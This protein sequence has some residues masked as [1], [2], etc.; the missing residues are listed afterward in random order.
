MMIIR[1]FVS[2]TP[3]L[4]WIG[5]KSVS[6]YFKGSLKASIVIRDLSQRRPRRPCCNIFSTA[7]AAPHAD[8]NFRDGLRGSEKADELLNWNDG[9]MTAAITPAEHIYPF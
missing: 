6:C 5:D 1:L 3:D 4:Q 8:A 2:E 9:V 7:S